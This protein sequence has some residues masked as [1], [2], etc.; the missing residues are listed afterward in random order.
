MVAIE[1]EIGLLFSFVACHPADLSRFSISFFVI[2]V[3]AASAP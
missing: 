2:W 1:T 3:T